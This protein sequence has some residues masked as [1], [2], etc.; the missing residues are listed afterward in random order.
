MADVSI[1]NVPNWLPPLVVDKA[2]L[3]KPAI[4][5]KISFTLPPSLEKLAKAK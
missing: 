3:E 1:I 4:D 2:I 5:V